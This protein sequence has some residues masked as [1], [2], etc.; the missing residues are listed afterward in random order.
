MERQLN[1][2]IFLSI[3]FEIQST[4]KYIRE[5][6][7]IHSFDLASAMY[8]RFKTGPAWNVNTRTLLTYP[9]HSLGYHLGCFLIK[10]RFEP[11]PRCE[12]HD[13]FHVITNYNIDTKQEI[14]MQFWLFGNG[15]RS[16]FVFLA[17]LVG[18][19]LYVD[20]YHAF[21]KAYTTGK[22]AKRIH[23]LDFKQLLASPLAG[24]K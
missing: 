11:Q 2:P 8:M 9:A 1:K 7:V 13:V 14:A 12:N 24:F 5:I 15:K 17:I 16:L 19:L 20:G 23:D 22:N 10:H 6:F 3:Y 21:A 18:V 4:L